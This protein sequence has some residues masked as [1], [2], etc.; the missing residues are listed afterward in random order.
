MEIRANNTHHCIP[1]PSPGQKRSF[2]KMLKVFLKNIEILLKILI[3][4][5]MKKVGATILKNVGSN[6]F[7]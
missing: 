3:D 2:I 5:Y 4:I 1:T 7:L 6:P